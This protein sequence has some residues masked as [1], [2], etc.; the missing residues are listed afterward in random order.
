MKKDNWWILRPAWWPVK[1][2]KHVIRQKS[3]DN[4]D[5]IKTKIW[6][7]RRLDRH[8]WYSWKT[9]TIVWFDETVEQQMR[10]QPNDKKSDDKI[11]VGERVDNNFGIKIY[12]LKI[13]Q[14]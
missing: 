10:K 11:D 8:W 3:D 12:I 2:W 1:L 4:K 6:W 5:L 13:C 9:K 14:L 7:W